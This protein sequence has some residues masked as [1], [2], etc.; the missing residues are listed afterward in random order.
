[1]GDVTLEPDGV[2]VLTSG[3]GMGVD[4]CDDEG[5]VR[6]CVEE[7]VFCIVGTVV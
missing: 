5:V 7:G 2:G 1:M 3:V 6:A 4:S